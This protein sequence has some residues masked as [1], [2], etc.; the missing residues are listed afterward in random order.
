MSKKSTLKWSVSI[1]AAI[2]L[3][4]VC[5]YVVCDGSRSDTSSPENKVAEVDPGA[6][7]IA[8]GQGKPGL[9]QFYTTSCGWCTKMEPELAQINALLKEEVFVFKMDARKN[10]PQVRVYGIEVVPTTVVF[11]SMGQVKDTVI[12]YKTQ[13][14]LLEILKDNELINPVAP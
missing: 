14:Q 13:E 11:D 12:G 2:L 6:L 5:K 1:A 7:E 10:A 4:L 3:F 8:L 9:L